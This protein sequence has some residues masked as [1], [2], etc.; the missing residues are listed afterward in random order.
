LNTEEKYVEIRIEK[1][2]KSWRL[3]GREAKGKHKGGR[4][5]G[6]YWI[7]LL[8]HFPD[9]SAEGNPLARK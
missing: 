2:G 4:I 5:N 3:G 7:S 9:G 1:T 8:Q 6:I